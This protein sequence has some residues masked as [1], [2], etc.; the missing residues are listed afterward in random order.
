MKKSYC[1]L[2]VLL[3]NTL[4]LLAQQDPKP[5][6]KGNVGTPEDVVVMD[7]QIIQGS[8]C[9]GFDCV[10]NES[11][12]FSTIKLKENNLR[13]TFEDTSVGDFPSND[14]DLTAN[15]TNSGGQSYFEITDITNGTSPFRVRAQAPSFSLYISPTGNVGI[16][17]DDPQTK[18]HVNGDLTVGNVVSPSDRRL[19]TDIQ[20]LGQA[21]ALIAQLAPKTYRYRSEEMPNM[22]LPTG[23]QFGLIAQDVEKVLPALVNTYAQTSDG[24]SEPYKGLN[25]VGLIPVLVRTAQEQQETIVQQQAAIAQLQRTLADLQAQVNA[26]ATTVQ[27]SKPAPN[28]QVSTAQPLTTSTTQK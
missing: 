1:L 12:G 23:P 7:D 3:C 16:G 26:L 5:K 4:P 14:W 2:V 22:G 13:L 24:A 11:F 27:G 20:P 17:T 25:Y 8:A 18:M 19:K 10:N 21:T 9:V 15:G 28:G 6:P